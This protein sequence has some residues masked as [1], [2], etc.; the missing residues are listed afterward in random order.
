MTRIVV[1]SKDAERIARS[2][3]DLIGPKGLD[4][5]RRKAVNSVGS[6]LRKAVR[7]IGPGVFNT[8][9]KALSPQGRAARPGADPTYKLFLARTIP[10]EK[11]RAKA[12]K[13]SRSQGRTRLTITLPDGRKIGFRSVARDGPGSRFRLLAAGALPARHL[14][15]VFVNPKQAFENYPELVKLRKKAER[16]LPEEV[17]RQITEHMKRRRR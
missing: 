17:A 2:F 16:D 1:S 11:L 7:V 6:S 3:N 15:G 4:R 12:R 10:V 13:L 5:I 14:G 8:S 9:A